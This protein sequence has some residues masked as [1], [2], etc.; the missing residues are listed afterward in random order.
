M[1]SYIPLGEMSFYC[2][3]S[4][5]TVGGDIELTKRFGAAK[6]WHFLSIV[7]ACKVKCVLIH[8]WNDIYVDTKTLS[9]KGYISMYCT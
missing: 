9:L 7:F 8:L 1:T 6:L 5:T 2:D 3:I 4:M